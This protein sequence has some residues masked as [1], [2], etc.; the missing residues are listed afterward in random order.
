MSRSEFRAQDG[1]SELRLSC[2]CCAITRSIGNRSQKPCGIAERNICYGALLAGI[3]SRSSQVHK[4]ESPELSASFLSKSTFHWFGK[5]INSSGKNL[6]VESLWDLKTEDFA[7]TQ[8][9]VFEA[10][11]TKLT[12]SGNSRS[13]HLT[14]NSRFPL[15]AFVRQH[16]TSLQEVYSIMIARFR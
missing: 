10:N 11:L 4:N 14:Y 6:S 8:S 2:T 12:S 9:R 15:I 13:V 1:S 3:R 7:Q 16:R 5:F